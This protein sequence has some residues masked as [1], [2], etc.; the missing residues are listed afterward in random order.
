MRSRVQL[1]A[2][3]RPSDGR[4]QCAILHLLSAHDLPGASALA[5]A[6]GH[7]RLASL[8]PSAG[9]HPETAAAL[10]QQLTARGGGPSQSRAAWQAAGV[11]GG[12]QP[13]ISAEL[14][15]TYKLLSG[16][17]AAALPLLAAPR[18]C[19]QRAFGLCLWYA[20]PPAAGVAHAL[21][22]FDDLLVG[23][24]DIADEAS[25]S[26]PDESVTRAPPP[27]PQHARAS[28]YPVLAD[29]QFA[30]LRLRASAADSVS[31]QSAASRD[32]GA[33][34]ALS[35]LGCTRSYSPDALDATVPWLM[36]SLLRAVRALPSSATNAASA[37]DPSI[38]A[39]DDI[40]MSVE[41]AVESSTATPPF[42]DSTSS[43]ETLAA[44]DAAF[45]AATLACADSLLLA[46]EPLW[47]VYVL[48]H[49]PAHSA[50]AAAAKEAAI[51]STLS[52]HWLAIRSSGI[53]S[54]VI[55]L[56]D[57]YAVPRAWL[58]A[59]DAHL[60]RRDNEP[61]VVVVALLEAGEAEE[62]EGVLFE[63][64]APVLMT[65]AGMKRLRELVAQCGAT[66]RT[67]RARTLQ[68]RHR[69][70]ELASAFSEAA[71]PTAR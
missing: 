24:V 1:T 66:P 36:L 26:A 55:F 45:A 21:Q 28:S 62:A 51:R 47:A 49:L 50:S 9:L 58:S 7:P 38:D 13:L 27:V 4:Q 34:E 16:D 53:E 57:S 52:R 44:S 64:V 63:E 39:D 67:A 65:P 59:A 37:E 5:A 41:A 3:G 19:W 61:Q 32:V 43:A 22:T 29:A 20:T 40:G 12:E 23:A 2:R 17:V 33:L 25:T 35:Q 68:V 69:C 10:A 14:E 46:E 70:H 60:A 42:S 54:A 71:V 48:L 11:F 15:A 56:C 31:S 30:L 18:L 8:V 6:S